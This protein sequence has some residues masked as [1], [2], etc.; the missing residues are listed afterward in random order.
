MSLMLRNV[1]RPRIN[2]CKQT[3]LGVTRFSRS[4]NLAAALSGSELSVIRLFNILL[5]TYGNCI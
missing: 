4:C 1:A 5:V 2:H 3:D